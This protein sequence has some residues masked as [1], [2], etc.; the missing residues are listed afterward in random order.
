MNTFLQTF[1]QAGF[2]E[3]SGYGLIIN[4]LIYIGSLA[5]YSLLSRVSSHGELSK[6]QPILRSDIILS[7]ITV[8]CNTVVFIL[9]V[10]LW[11]YGIIQLDNSRTA[12]GIVLE[13]LFLT[14]AMD[15]LMYVFHRL[16]HFVSYFKQVHSRHHDHQ[17]TNMLSL[18]V[19]HPIESIG[20]GLMMLFVICIFPFS[21]IGISVYLLINSMW[22]TIGHLNRSFLP[23][24]L[25]RAA[26]KI[27]LCTSEFHYL[28][29]QHPG[30][31]F[32]FY[33]SVWDMIFN[34]LHPSLRKSH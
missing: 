1:Q 21:A 11:K 7:W 9:G 15:F 12:F 23:P 25:H 29:H 17:S 26:K 16:V 13:V 19:L 30:F 5:L 3:V 18:F 20:F 33:S 34:T 27:Y 32:G 6:Q 10:Y 24:S 14:L 4:V 28:H 2:L 31:N 22:G 8:F